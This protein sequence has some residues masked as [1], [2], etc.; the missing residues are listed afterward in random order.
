MLPGTG[1]ALNGRLRPAL[2]FGVPTALVLLTAWF[3]ARS[4]QPTMLAARLIAPPVLTA[5]LV[6]NIAIFA[7]RAVAALQAFTDRRYPGRP[8]RVGVVGLVALL[9]S[10]VPAYRASRLDPATVLRD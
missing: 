5:L 1:Q 6:L 9:A 4:D 7:W 3:V 10:L 8:G 2:F